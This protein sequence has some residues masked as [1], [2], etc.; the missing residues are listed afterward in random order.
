MSSSSSRASVKDLTNR[1][2][3]VDRKRGRRRKTTKKKSAGPPPLPVRR[4]T[5]PGVHSS[6]IDR[7]TKR[8]HR[9]SKSVWERGDVAAKKKKQ[10]GSGGES[11]G[12][13]LGEAFGTIRASISSMWTPS[14]NQTG[15]SNLPSSP[16]RHRSASSP[17]PPRLCRLCRNPMRR[18]KQGALYCSRECEAYQAA[19]KKTGLDTK[20]VS[21]GWFP[22]RSR[23]KRSRSVIERVK[24]HRVEKKKEHWGAYYLSRATISR[25]KKKNKIASQTKKK[26]KKAT[27]REPPQAS[28]SPRIS[29][30]SALERLSLAPTSASERR[31]VRAKE[32]NSLVRSTDR[33]GPPPIP[34]SRRV[35]ARS[36][37]SPAVPPRL[38][39]TKRRDRKP[40]AVSRSSSTPKATLTTY[41]SSTTRRA[42]KRNDESTIRTPPALKKS[43]RTT[44]T[45]RLRSVQTITPAKSVPRRRV[46]NNVGLQKKSAGKLFLS[47]KGLSSVDDVLKRASKKRGCK[48]TS[49]RFEGKK[50]RSL[51]TQTTRPMRVNRIPGK[52]QRLK[53]WCRQRVDGIGYNVKINNFTSNFKSGRAF[54]ALVYSAC[55]SMANL[56][57]EH[58]TNLTKQQ[59]LELAFRVA[60]SKLGVEPILEPEDI[61]DLPRPD[62][63]VVVLYVS[64]LHRAITSIGA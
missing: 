45:T 52:K 14:S 7:I 39:S 53:A 64:M 15:K 10:N 20:K 11:R 26:K 16:T 58:T 18:T 51:R 56:R 50:K 8:D 49:Q 6:R 42:T 44:K 17:V 22:R 4:R 47:K 38:I 24:I 40:P 59:R 30:A 37:K 1:F 35:H 63:K 21:E 28:Q 46:D 9:G 32:Q 41:P 43:S 23:E 19:L 57:H 12:L 61:T 54:C 31:R 13:S 29:T 55:P 5:S 2:G 33:N 3:G 34:T 48:G 60:H 62:E 25:R 27:K 36:T